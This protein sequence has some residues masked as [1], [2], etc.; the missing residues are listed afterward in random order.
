MRKEEIDELVRK[1]ILE[2]GMFHDPKTGHFTSN[3]PGVVKSL[4]KKGARD[5][6]IDPK[7]VGRG[8]VTKTGKVSAK[9]GQ[10]YGSDP[11]GR[12]NIDGEK[13]NP[14]FR[15]SD[16]KERYEESLSLKDFDGL[17]AS[18]SIPLESLLRALSDLDA[19]L[20]EGSPS[21]AEERS[22][23][24]RNLLKSLNSIALAS[25]GDLIPKKES[26][27]DRSKHANSHYRGS[28]IKNDGDRESEAR[29]KSARTKKIKSAVGA[30]TEPFNRGEKAL[31]STNSLW[32][33]SVK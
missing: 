33:W 8:T 25:K 21:C 11:C 30:Y 19:Q 18:S 28:E 10:N 12:M 9:F 4:S 24:M 16:Y 1:V 32:E 14:R 27:E 31:L 29:K 6:G 26:Q 5:A 22:E 13:V 15:C 7:H 2:V 20:I 3:R 17:K 23:W